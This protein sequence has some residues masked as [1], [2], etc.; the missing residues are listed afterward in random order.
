M[1]AAEQERVDPGGRRQREDELAGRVALAEQRRERLGHGRLRPRVPRGRPASTSGTNVGR[2][3]LVHLDR[4]VL[5]LD[6][7]RSRRASGRSPGV[8]ITPTRRLRVARAAA[9][10]PGRMTPRIGRS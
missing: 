8:A 3:V 7:R 4:R 9:A 5:V 6:R 1:G 2:R 10:A